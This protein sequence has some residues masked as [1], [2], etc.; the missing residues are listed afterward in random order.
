[1]SER[2][3]LP[4]RRQALTFEFRHRGLAYSCTLGRYPDGTIG[5]IFL[6]NHKAGSA[7]GA[8][9]RDAAVAVSLGLQGGVPLHTFRGAILRDPDGSASTPLGHALDLIT[10][11]EAEA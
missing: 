6:S 11:M 3:R 4:D 7:A 9:A 2:K 10:T 8:L 5:E 1:M